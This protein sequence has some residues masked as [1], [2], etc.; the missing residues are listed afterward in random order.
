MGKTLM[1]SFTWLPKMLVNLEIYYFKEMN[2]KQLKK[3]HLAHAV[4]FLTKHNLVISTIKDTEMFYIKFISQINA[5]G[6]FMW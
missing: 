3:K 6:F 2:L 1:F 5:L 4:N